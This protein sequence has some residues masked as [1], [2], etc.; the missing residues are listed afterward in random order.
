[1]V[2]VNGLPRHA[3]IEV[4]VVGLGTLMQVRYVK[5]MYV[6]VY[7]LMCVLMYVL[8]VCICSRICCVY[9]MCGSSRIVVYY[10]I[11]YNTELPIHRVYSILC[12][13]HLLGN[14]GLATDQWDDCNPIVGVEERKFIHSRC[15]AL[16]N[17]SIR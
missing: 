6:P 16:T 13:L 15:H 12:Y 14:E 4:V 2:G 1:M 7:V 11:P 9:E 3:L 5:L 8:C 10:Y 17:V